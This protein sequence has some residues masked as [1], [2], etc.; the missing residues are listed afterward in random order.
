MYLHCHKYKC[1]HS[2]H[3]TMDRLNIFDSIAK[4]NYFVIEENEELVIKP[5]ENEWNRGDSVRGTRWKDDTFF[6]IE[7]KLRNRSVVSEQKVGVRPA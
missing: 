5:E 4:K 3:L 7:K 1:F 2:V 6:V